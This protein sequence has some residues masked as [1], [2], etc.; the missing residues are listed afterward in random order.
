MQ[1][2]ATLFDEK[3]IIKAGIE[4]TE[5]EQQLKEIE[6]QKDAL[7]SLI[8]NANTHILE[9]TQ[10]S[11]D[12][13]DTLYKAIT[14]LTD[15]GTYFV[16]KTHEFAYF[17]FKMRKYYIDQLLNYIEIEDSYNHGIQTNS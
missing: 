11:I 4:K 1:A 15:C 6:K 3:K 12:G 14:F 2:Q 9:F 5:L 13:I 16:S 10:K 8:K 7:K 17:W